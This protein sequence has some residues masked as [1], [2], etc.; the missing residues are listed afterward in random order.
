MATVQSLA[1]KI[2]AILYQ[3][4]G[5][6]VYR[7]NLVGMVCRCSTDLMGPPE[8]QQ[9]MVEVLRSN[10]IESGVE[11]VMPWYMVEGPP[12]ELR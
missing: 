3:N 4:A 5:E 9:A 6:R 1:D 12:E 11:G 7:A 10:T 8:F 2:L